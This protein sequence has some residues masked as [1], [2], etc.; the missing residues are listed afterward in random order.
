M[1][2]MNG[3]VL[4]GLHLDP[5]LQR[6]SAR[7]YQR[8]Q[9][10]MVDHG[11]FDLVVERRGTDGLPHG[12][13]CSPPAS[14]RIDLGQS[15]GER[16][17]RVGGINTP[18]FQMSRRYLKKPDMDTGLVEEIYRCPYGFCQLFERR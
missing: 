13:F 17:E 4:A 3:D 11:K 16:W 18:D 8:V 2:G 5:A 7:E 12:G 1:R 15:G 9:A 14:R 10:L 6:P